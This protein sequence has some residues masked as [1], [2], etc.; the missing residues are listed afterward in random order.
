MISGSTPTAGVT[1]VFVPYLSCLAGPLLAALASFD[2][3]RVPI[4]SEIRRFQTGTVCHRSLSTLIA[5]RAL[6]GLV[7]TELSASGT[8][9]LQEA[10]R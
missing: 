8:A 7:R 4:A 5:V 6:I 10:S 1:A 9:Y 3:R 2:Q